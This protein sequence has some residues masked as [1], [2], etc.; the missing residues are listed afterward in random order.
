MA[1]EMKTRTLGRSGLQV[2]EFGCGAGPLGGFYGPVTSAEAAATVDAMWAAGCRYYDTAPLYGYG[3]SELRLGHVLREMPRDAY[4][5]STKVG[6]HFVPLK[7]GEDTSGLRPG[8]LPFRP[9]LDYSYDGALRSLEHSLLR[10]GIERADIVLLHDLDDQAHGDEAERY[11]RDAEKG[12]FK[13]LERL[14]ADGTIKAIGIGVN[15][16]N[17]AIRLIEALDLDCVLIAGRYT[18]LNQEALPELYPLCQQRGIG[19][20]AAG[21]FNGG[22]LARGVKPGVRYNYGEAPPE[23]VEHLNRLNAVCDRWE[24]PIRAAALQFSLAHPVVASVVTG[25]MSAAEVED[26]LAGLQAPI[27]DDFWAELRNEGLI[28]A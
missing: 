22:L 23:V 1:H 10:L 27:P 8:G 28:P 2:S 20:L 12:A 14:R 4:V 15:R 11:F 18:L 13:A 3:R 7:P 21:P 5:L 6:R 9:I 19:M 16:V 25:A 24:V 26:N 17:W